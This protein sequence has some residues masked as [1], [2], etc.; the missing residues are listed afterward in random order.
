MVHISRLFDLC[1]GHAIIT[2]LNGPLTFS[3]L[4][5]F[6]LKT[7]T[8]SSLKTKVFLDKKVFL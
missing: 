2:D 8:H 6:Q 5:Q 4:N 7:V 1:V 3:V